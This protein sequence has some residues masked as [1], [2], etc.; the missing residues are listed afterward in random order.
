MSI[1]KNTIIF[2]VISAL[3]FLYLLLSSMIIVKPESVVILKELK[4]DTDQIR[5]ISRPLINEG[6]KNRIFFKQPAIPGTG[7]GYVEEIYY[8]DDPYK[9]KTSFALYTLD[10]I[11]GNEEDRNKVRAFTISGQIKGVDNWDYF[12]NKLNVEEINNN[13][14]PYSRKYTSR[15]EILAEQLKFLLRTSNPSQY[16][17]YGAG[18]EKQIMNLGQKIAYLKE[19]L[20]SRRNFMVAFNDKYGF[21][22]ADLIRQYMIINT[23]WYWV[24][25]VNLFENLI[26][27][28]KNLR[29][30]EQNVYS[31]VISRKGNANKYIANEDYLYQINIAGKIH[32]YEQNL[33]Q[34]EQTLENLEQYIAQLNK[35]TSPEDLRM[36]NSISIGFIQY[37]Q[38]SN[39]R[40]IEIKQEELTASIA[41]Y[42]DSTLFSQLAEAVNYQKLLLTI[43]YLDTYEDQIHKSYEFSDSDLKNSEDTYKYLLKNYSQL[44]EKENWENYLPSVNKEINIYL[45]NNPEIP[46]PEE[47]VQI[48]TNFKLYEYYLNNIEP[49]LKR[50]EIPENHYL[51][52]MM[53]ALNSQ[54]QLFLSDKATVNQILTSW[55][56]DRESLFL[57]AAASIIS[58]NWQLERTLSI[59]DNLDA[60]KERELDPYLLFESRNYDL[61]E[62]ENLWN[63]AIDNVLYGPDLSTER[64]YTVHNVEQQE[65]INSIADLYDVNPYDVYYENR[66]YL[67]F[68]DI[69]AQN[70]MNKK[71]EYTASKDLFTGNKDYELK[72]DQNIFIPAEDLYSNNW[73]NLHETKKEVREFY[74]NQFVYTNLEKM[75]PNAFEEFINQTDYISNLEHN[76]GIEFDQ[77]N[78]SIED[79]NIFSNPR[80]GEVDND[81]IDLYY[82]KTLR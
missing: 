11:T 64:T 16:Y 62:S 40:L 65:T 5:L 15:V 59:I 81:F 78:F 52:P 54:P 30:Y 8:F 31:K 70:E 20:V 19:E 25:G 72:T 32:Y 47:K 37:L 3:I 61:D 69:N 71:M 39:S 14:S 82:Q 46:I 26:N 67:Q 68:N 22:D 29:E 44:L 38:S 28:S 53:E 66:Y 6:G 41:Q 80:T 4:I 18:T 45:S 60:F 33:I 49:A 51:Y 21:P 23:P 35:S 56:Q 57:K 55:L 79:R 17:P 74:I 7:I 2:S 34:N 77:L 1:K 48:L 27:Q 73:S 10:Q 42:I 43:K 36:G 12:L 75:V 9:F 13:R 58:Y 24:Y 50:N 76:Y 63:A